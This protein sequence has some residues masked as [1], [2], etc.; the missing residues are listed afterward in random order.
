MYDNVSL[1]G[2]T[3]EKQDN[4]ILIIKQALVDHNAVADAEINLSAAL[5]RLV[6]NV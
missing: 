1:F 2:D 3:E 6:R 5:I 4:A